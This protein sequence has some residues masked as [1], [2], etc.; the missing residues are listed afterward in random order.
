MKLPSKKKIAITAFIIAALGLLTL[1]GVLLVAMPHRPTVSVDDLA[2]MKTLAHKYLNER[3]RL[4]VST[5]PQNNPNIAGAPVI[6]PSEMSPELAARQKEDVEKLRARGNYGGW[7]DFATSLGVL[8]ISGEG[9]DIALC[10]GIATSY[11]FA[12]TFYNPTDPNSYPPCSSLG[13]ELYF[14]FA[15]KGNRWILTDAKL[16]YAGTDPP[17]TEPSVKP[18]EAGTPRVLAHPPKEITKVPEEI[19][20][21][22]I[23]ATTKTLNKWAVSENP[24]SE[25]P[26]TGVGPRWR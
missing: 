7:D 22:D 19:E 18:E 10:V 16:P 24:W 20:R 13:Y 9:D 11:H 2:E 6:D 14:K 21:L 23:A 1:A 4:L 3:N 15:R 26:M 5:D 12:P 25:D 17:D 8:D